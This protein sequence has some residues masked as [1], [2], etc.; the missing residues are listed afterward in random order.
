MRADRS[1]TPAPATTNNLQ[2]APANMTHLQASGWNQMTFEVPKTFHDSTIHT[3]SA[4][5]TQPSPPQHPHPGPF[6][7]SLIAAGSEGTSGAAGAGQAALL[8]VV[9][10]E[11]VGTVLAVQPR[12]ARQTGAVSRSVVAPTA[13]HS[14]AVAWL[15]CKRE[16]EA[17]RG[18]RRAQ[19][20]GRSRTVG[21]S[22]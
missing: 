13:P 1:A 21:L 14:T 5:Q 18:V 8:A 11:A 9:G 16:R 15:S 19:G 4:S 20:L 2:L 12:I 7:Y 6:G 3:R 17:E 22:A 10:V